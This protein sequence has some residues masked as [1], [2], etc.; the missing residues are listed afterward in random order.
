MTTLSTCLWFA[1]EAEE[2]ARFYAASIPGG[3][4]GEVVRTPPADAGPPGVLFARFEMGGQPFMALNGN[5]GDAFTNAVSLVATCADQAE[6]DRVWDALIDGGAPI[7]CGWL[8]DRYGVAWQVVPA[9][10]MRLM[11]TADEAGRARFMAA[12]RQMVKL[13]LAT[14]EAAVAAP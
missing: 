11:E 13:D 12:M 5:P 9:G 4:M 1:T 6:L 14:L 3:R 7:A 2:A 8:K 10:L